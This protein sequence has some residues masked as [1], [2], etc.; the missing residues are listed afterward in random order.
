[1]L[2]ELEQISEKLKKVSGLIRI[3]ILSLLA[4]R[5]A[6]SSSQISEQLSLPEK[7][8]SHHLNILYGS[9]LV[10][11]M[12]SGRNMIY[13]SNREVMTKL[14][15]NITELLNGA[16]DENQRDTRHTTISSPL[17]QAGEREDNTDRDTG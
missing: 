4:R 12:Q 10:T 16:T 14:T 6:L 1:M 15:T 11:R 3:R 13:M 17:R 7:T 9:N 8:T 2:T 5:T